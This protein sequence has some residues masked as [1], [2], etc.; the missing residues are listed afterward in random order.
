[1]PERR[2]WYEDFCAGA[3]EFI[4]SNGIK[5]NPQVVKTGGLESIPASWDDLRV[6]QSVFKLCAI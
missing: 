4:E 1:M 5:G 3:Q 6:S 2:K